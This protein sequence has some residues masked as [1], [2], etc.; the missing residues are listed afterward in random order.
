MKSSAGHRAGEIKARADF[1]AIAGCYTR[2]RRAG[3]QWVGL[4]PFHAERHP[5]FYVE[6]VRRVFYCF[7]CGAGGDVFDFVMRAEQCSFGRA[8]EVVGGARSKQCA[9]AWRTGA[10]AGAQ[11]PS[12]RSG[13][14]RIARAKAQPS[15]FVNAWRGPQME[16]PGGCAA[17]RAAL[18]LEMKG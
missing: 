16:P 4:C 1:L 5:S 6:P 14:L 11:P 2:L 3:R 18:L 9:T 7:G 8:L 15:R 10:G 13:V 12:P 17:E